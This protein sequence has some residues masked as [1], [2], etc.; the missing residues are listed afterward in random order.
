[1]LH[2]C[3]SRLIIAYQESN[4][5]F[6]HFCNKIIYPQHLFENFGK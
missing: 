3:N 2:H 6:L 5:I 1:L 4:Y